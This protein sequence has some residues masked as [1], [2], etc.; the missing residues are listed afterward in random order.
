MLA[1]INN[2]L[3]REAQ[4]HHHEHPLASE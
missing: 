1:F 3:L 2:Q 4:R